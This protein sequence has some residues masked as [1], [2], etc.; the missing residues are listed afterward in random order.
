MKLVTRIYLITVTA[1][2]AALSSSAALAQPAQPAREEFI[3]G[4]TDFPVRPATRNVTVTIEEAGGFDW[5]D[6]GIGAGSGAFAALLAAAAVA[7]LRRRST[8]ILG[9]AGA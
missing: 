7:V 4:V 1:A 6:A 2:V 8:G 5:A 9:T 3:P